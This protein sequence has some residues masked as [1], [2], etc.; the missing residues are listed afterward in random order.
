MAKHRGRFQA[1]NDIE[2]SERWNQDEPLTAT[3]AFVLRRRLEAKLSPGERRKRKHAFQ[4]AHEYVETVARAGV[5]ITARERW[6]KSFS[7]DPIDESHVRVDIEIK[8]GTAFVR[9]RKS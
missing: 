4:E 3:D 6:H 1:Q 9:E 2:E 5:G 7:D 8:S